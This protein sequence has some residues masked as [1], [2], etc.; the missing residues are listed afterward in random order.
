MFGTINGLGNGGRVMAIDR[1]NHIPAIGRKALW[2]VV[3]KPR[4]HLAVNGDSVVVIQRNEFIELPSAGQ[5]AG[6]VADTLHQAAVAHKHIGMVV[7]YSMA[8]AVEFLSQQFFCQRHANGVRN[9]LAQRAGGGFYTGGDADF[10][11]ARGF[12]VQLAKVFELVHGQLVATQVQQGINKHG[13]VTIGKHKAVTV[14]PVWIGGAV[15][16]ML[17]PQGG[18]HIGHS[19][20]G[21]GVSGVGE[22]NCVHC[23]R[24]DGA[25][26]LLGICHEGRL[27]GS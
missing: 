14:H 10:G 18:R 7:N 5:G 23:Q 11:V 6:F 27:R 12:A 16:Q 26:H 4:G 15:L 24:A 21:A 1:V 17:T 19:H 9:A 25:G 8:F 22:L 3:D 2:R 13:A 20:G